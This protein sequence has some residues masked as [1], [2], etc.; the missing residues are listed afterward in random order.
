MSLKS[1]SI[2]NK[3]LAIFIIINTLNHDRV[4]G[5][6]YE[7][8]SW[9]LKCCSSRNH[10]SMR[11]QGELS[12]Q[13]NKQLGIQLAGLESHELQVII[14]PWPQKRKFEILQDHKPGEPHYQ[15]RYR[16]MELGQKCC[17]TAGRKISKLQ[18]EWSP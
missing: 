2:L 13:R 3:V 11:F 17:Y 16:V 12:S 10:T 4:V 7:L 1:S 6:I 9:Y 15:L 5:T 14:D 18:S 8:W